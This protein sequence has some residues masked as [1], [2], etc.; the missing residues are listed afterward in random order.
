MSEGIYEVFIIDMRNI[1]VFGNWGL[2]KFL[3]FLVWERIRFLIFVLLI[4][5]NW[6]LLGRKINMKL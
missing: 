4:L 1:K 3:D 5:S 2:D 6:K